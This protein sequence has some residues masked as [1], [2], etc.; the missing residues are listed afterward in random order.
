[1]HL[2]QG[3]SDGKLRLSGKAAGEMAGKKKAGDSRWTVFG[4]NRS[5][6]RDIVVCCCSRGGENFP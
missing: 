5:R 6:R 4:K 3:G 2:V 1:M